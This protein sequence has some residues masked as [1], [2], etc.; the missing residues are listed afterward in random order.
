MG[1][2]LGFLPFIVFFLLMRLA[3]P[4]AG[5][6]AALATSLILALRDW[7]RGDSIKILE[8]GS[9]A[10]FAVL[11]LYTLIAA[12]QWTVATVRLAVD[13]GLFAIAAASLAID[14]PFTLQ[15][16]RQQ[17]PKEYWTTPLFLNTNRLI[18]AVWAA[19]FAVLVAADAA[20]EY[21]PA[22]PLSADITASIAAL[23]AA[24][25][26]TLWYPARVR[27]LAGR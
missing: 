6:A 26:F 2:L 22:I 12:P 1:Y 18:T 7:R 23:G 11:V 8:I 17:V 9:L 21:L 24:V 15:Y 16:A 25:A 4:L 19:A 5:L 10:L 14:R 13:A 3:S 20:A 27:R